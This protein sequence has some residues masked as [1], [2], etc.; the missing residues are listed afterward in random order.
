MFRERRQEGW[1]SLCLSLMMVGAG[2]AWGLP[3]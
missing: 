2:R 1:L 3:V